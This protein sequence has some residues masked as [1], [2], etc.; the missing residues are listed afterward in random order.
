MIATIRWTAFTLFFV[1][2]AAL[3]HMEERNLLT[4]LLAAAAFLLFLAICWTFGAF[5]RDAWIGDA[6]DDEPASLLDLPDGRGRR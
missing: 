4:A 2:M 5:R 3:W 1:I 6:L